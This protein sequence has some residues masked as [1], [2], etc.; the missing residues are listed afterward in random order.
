M[1]TTHPVNLCLPL[2]LV[3][4][5]GL[6]WDSPKRDSGTAEGDAAPGDGDSTEM[7]SGAGA[8][9]Q[10]DGGH[11][12]AGAD[13]AGAEG[14]DDAGAEGADRD[15]AIGSEG[16]DD[17]EEPPPPCAAS[18][19]CG[20]HSTCDA[21]RDTCTCDQGYLAQGDA[22]VAD[23]CSPV[24]GGPSCGI[25]EECTAANG[26]ASCD[27]KSGFTACGGACVNLK[28]DPGH[29]GSC[30]TSC[31]LGASCGGGTCQQLADRLVLL[32][33]VS[34]ALLHSNTD[35]H[36]LRCWGDAESA[37][38]RET[39]ATP[40]EDQTL[41]SAIE[42]VPTVRALALTAERRCV[43][44]PDADVVRCWGLCGKDCGLDYHYD[45][46]E[47]ASTFRDVQ[48]SGVTAI[49][50]AAGLSA[51]T[52]G[53]TCAL[54]SAFSGVKCWGRMNN[55]L[56]TD[57][58]YDRPRGVITVIESEEPAAKMISGDVTATCAVLADGTV[59]CWGI[60]MQGQLG[61][62]YE[63]MARTAG[64]GVRVQRE[65]GAGNLTNAKEV[66]TDY[67]AACAVTNDGKLYCWGTSIWSGNVATATAKTSMKATQVASLSDIKQVTVGL[68]AVCALAGSGQVYCMGTK[69]AVGRG[70][71]AVP[72]FN[73]FFFI[74]PR[75]VPG[76]EHALEVRCGKNHCCARLADGGVKCW[77]DN[78][79][80]QLGDGT[81][82]T[83]YSPVYVKGLK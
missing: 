18:G 36:P 29:C 82:I 57:E 23:L 4:A 19:D 69:E 55:G 63:E 50:T 79:K 83:R 66:D 44:L 65:D 15:G 43:I 38:F 7:D 10:V 2:L 48:I 73:D 64:S 74:V 77:G 16:D 67:G 62:S 58:M 9:G 37:L 54:S 60:N 76:L 51:S 8:N 11:N 61:V 49:S 5:C 20:E 41:P 32:E 6:D 80:G 13:D 56:I 78:S 24:H 45:S 52:G 46:S 22:C 47:P 81:K 30:E 33:Q 27:C 70:V 28:T 35:E 68:T 59:G 21:A 26:A 39:T 25:N 75:A 3:T 72:D 34:C 42:G 31:G 12:E 53:N 1:K 71:D 17:G 14:A 40:L